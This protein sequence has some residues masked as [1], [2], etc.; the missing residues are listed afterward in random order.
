MIS[1]Q[2]KE[3]C[4]EIAIVG[5][6]MVGATM[7]CLLRDSPYRIALIDRMDFA[8]QQSSIALGKERFDPRVSALSAITKK[9]LPK[10]G[11]GTR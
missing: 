9:Y 7:A 4:F 5:G 11:S 2:K 3:E 8:R 1:A 6:G 10:L